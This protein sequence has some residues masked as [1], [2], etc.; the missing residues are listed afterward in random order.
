LRSSHIFAF[1]W[2]DMYKNFIRGFKTAAPSSE[3][4]TQYVKR[5]FGDNYLVNLN[6][7]S[8]ESSS[9]GKDGT[10]PRQLAPL[11]RSMEELNLGVEPVRDYLFRLRDERIERLKGT[12]G[13]QRKVVG[14][15]I[16][17]AKLELTRLKWTN[18]GRVRKSGSKNPRAKRPRLERE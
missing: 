7:V 12:Q 13:L 15:D 16:T 1:E 4:E 18:E 8:S 6:L 9:N 11:G 10:Y 5:I 17:L 2:N 3:N 14:Q